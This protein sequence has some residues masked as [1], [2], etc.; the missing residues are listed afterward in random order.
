MA[1]S[2]GKIIM[3]QMFKIVLACMLSH[4]LSAAIET[5][6]EKTVDTIVLLRRLQKHVFL[7]TA[8]TIEHMINTI[9]QESMPAPAMQPTS[10]HF[11]YVF[12][13]GVWQLLY[14]VL[15][16]LSCLLLYYRR[17]KIMVF[18]VLVI[19]AIPLVYSRYEIYHRPAIVRTPALAIYVGPSN[20][21]PVKLQLP[22]LTEVWIQKE[23]YVESEAW[24]YI[25]SHAGSGWVKACAIR[26]YNYE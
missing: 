7:D 4:E 21:Y 6:S 17:K 20:T 1:Q 23:R 19:S 18:I 16:W 22:G 13:L 14:M 3:K 8:R 25:T 15:F 10:V 24:L 2:V 5:V 11:F 9:K 26:E 12:P